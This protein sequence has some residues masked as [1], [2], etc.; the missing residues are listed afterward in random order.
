MSVEGRRVVVTGASSGLGAH[1]VRLLA[2]R[3]AHVV[4]AGR[5]VDRLEALAAEL[6]DAPGRVVPV[7]A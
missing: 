4:A 6:A 1:T 3:G 2:G 5:R 7:R